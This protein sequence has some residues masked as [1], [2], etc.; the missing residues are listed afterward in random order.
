MFELIL[1]IVNELLKGLN[2]TLDVKNKIKAIGVKDEDVS[3]QLLNLHTCLDRFTEV[4]EHLECTLRTYQHVKSDN[5]MKIIIETIKN[6][7]LEY[8]F[9][10]EDIHSILF[11]NIP[12]HKVITKGCYCGYEPSKV[13]K[14]LLV[15]SS[16]NYSSIIS[17]LEGEGH[18]LAEVVSHYFY[19]TANEDLNHLFKKTESITLIEEFT[20]FYWGYVGWPKK[21]LILENV[22]SEEAYSDKMKDVEK[23][24]QGLKQVALS[25]SG[26]KSELQTLLQKSFNINNFA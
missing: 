26:F 6:L 25:V 22:R 16:H 17:L 13:L 15:Y 18:S 20:P 14:V 2:S 10:L 1:K 19:D 8:K 7:I 21:A 11:D 24:L 4:I 9:I 5:D 3:L 23:Y 12:K